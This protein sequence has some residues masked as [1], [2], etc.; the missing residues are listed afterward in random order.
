MALRRNQF[1]DSDILLH[2]L[3]FPVVAEDAASEVVCEIQLHLSSC[4]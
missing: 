3:V 2:C 1:V 4:S